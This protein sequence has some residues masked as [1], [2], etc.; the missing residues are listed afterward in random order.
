MAQKRIGSGAEAVIFLEQGKDEPRIIKDRM[1][2]TYRHPLLDAEL[3]RTRTRREANILK[4]LDTLHVPGPKLLGTDRESVIEMGFI[5]GTPLK[6]LLDDEPEWAG[7]VGEGLARL[8]DAGIIH[9]DLTTSNMLVKDGT[10]FFIDFGLSNVSHG[11]EEK[12]VDIHLFRQ[13]LES[14][15]HAVSDKASR[16]FVKGYRKSKHAQ[17]VLDRL[18]VVERRGR[19]KGKY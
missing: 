4:K 17:N 15:H 16:A 12:A 13:A 2:K 11:A 10:L 5:D 8:H 1:P 3:R 18:E 7:A 14:K 9:G 6:R 19:N